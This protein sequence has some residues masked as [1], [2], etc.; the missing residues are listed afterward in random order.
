MGADLH[1]FAV[2]ANLPCSPLRLSRVDP[3][4]GVMNN[5]TLPTVDRRIHLKIVVLALFLG[6]LTLALMGIGSRVSNGLP[7][8]EAVFKRVA[9]ATPAGIA[10]SVI[11]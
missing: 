1:P 6:I 11:R 4:Q 8:T 7:N 10:Q 3:G 5:T 9:L 2:P